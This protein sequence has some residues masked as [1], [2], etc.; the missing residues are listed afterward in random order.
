MQA[1]ASY[2]SLPIRQCIMQPLLYLII[3]PNLS[4]FT[5]SRY[6]T[7]ACNYADFTKKVH[8]LRI[9]LQ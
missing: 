9:I 6:V 4:R 3:E 8:G 5:S 2:N 7:H 1:G